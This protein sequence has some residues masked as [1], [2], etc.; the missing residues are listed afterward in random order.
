MKRILAVLKRDL[1]STTRDAMLL[2]I[3]LA[4]LILGF[5]LRWV[6]PSVGRTSINLAVT[7]DFDPAMREAIEPYASL[8]IVGDADALER[9]VLAFDE[10]IGIEAAEG[11]YRLVLEGNESEASR[12]LAGI[13]LDRVLDGTGL[14][15]AP[16]E[17]VGKVR[18]PFREWIGVFM[19]LSAMFFGAMVM[20]FH[21]VED[22]ETR[23]IHALWVS[24]MSR[25][26]YI[27]ARSLLVLVLAVI[28]A[29]AGLWALGLTGYNVAQVALTALLGGVTG[30][31][32]GFL[33]GAT[34]PNQIA[35]FA[36]VKMGFLPLLLPAVAALLMP[37]RLEFLLYWAPTYWAY[38]A[39]KSILIDGAGWGALWVPLAAMLGLTVAALAAA[40]PWLRRGLEPASR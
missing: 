26:E 40:T 10:V 23:V 2:Y 21:I 30:I 5:G 24:P 19:A 25:G 9:R 4:P 16:I 18:M 28:T 17:Q 20:G 39:L 34:S 15:T 3:V 7:E 37:D 35:A 33:M 14:P 36:F 11:T 38:V 31:L 32:F 22:K 6:L 27:A 1:L 13:V 12:E 8:K 29:F